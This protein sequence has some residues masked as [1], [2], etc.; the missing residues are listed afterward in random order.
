MSKN[1]TQQLC[2]TLLKEG[3]TIRREVIDKTLYLTVKAFGHIYKIEAPYT[4]RTKIYQ[5]DLYGKRE[6][7][8]F[9]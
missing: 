5:E 6:V 7:L 2:K 8:Y 1:N 4:R 3:R 9:E